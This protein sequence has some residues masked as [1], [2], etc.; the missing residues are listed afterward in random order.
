MVREAMEKDT[1]DTLRRGCR[2]ARTGKWN[3]RGKGRFDQALRLSRYEIAARQE[4]LITM[5]KM[6]AV[7]GGLYAPVT[8]VIRRKTKVRRLR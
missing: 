7:G 6:A 2:T 8:K 4:T 1:R 5:V 3:A